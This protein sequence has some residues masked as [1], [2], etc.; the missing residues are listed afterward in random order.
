MTVVNKTKTNI[1]PLNRNKGQGAEWGDLIATWADTFFGWA[2]VEVF[3][4]KAKS[5]ITAINKIKT[6]I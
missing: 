2:D 6:N 4:N 1:T 3:I 5:S